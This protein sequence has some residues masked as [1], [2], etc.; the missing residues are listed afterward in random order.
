MNPA[1]RSRVV[2]AT[3][4]IIALFLAAWFM[5]SPVTA[6]LYLS[7]GLATAV[8]VLGL[9]IQWGYAGLFNAGILGF[10]ALG[11]YAVMWVSV[12][13][14]PEAI[15]AGGA[16]L[17]SVI[18]KL[19]VTAICIWVLHL[20]AKRLPIN[21][22]VWLLRTLQVSIALAG[23]IW[24]KTE[25]VIAVEAI[26]TADTLDQTMKGFIGGLGLPVLLGWAVGGV[27][28]GIAAWFI[29]KVT[30]G[31]RSDYLAIATLGIAEIIRTFL[32]NADW[33]TRGTLTV[34]PIDWPVPTP[35]E[36][37][38]MLESGLE[39]NLKWL[40]I[41]A[42]QTATAVGRGLFIAVSAIV[43]IILVLMMERALGSPWGRMMRAIRDNEDAAAAMGKN[44]VRRQLEVFVLGA[45][46]M[47]IGGAMLVS[48]N[49]LFDPSSYHPPR[50]TFLIWTMLIVGGSGN[51]LGAVFGALF[52]YMLWEMS[53]PI[54]QFL[55]FGGADM[56]T[57][58]IP[59][60]EPPVDLASRASQM[61]VIV[62]GVA[63]I[64]T[65]RYA[66]KG[67]IPER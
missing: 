33:L 10:I 46:L 63:L 22:P 53:E 45:I 48:L 11:G 16:G 61:R 19:A 51:N 60:F 38:G 47:G 1:N 62:I 50:Y 21:L 44:V 27:F 12:P 28:A 8:I 5:L 43:L 3:A 2:I 36:M 59:G 65:M 64:A 57:A 31:L 14:V 24:M 40:G 58:L 35:R 49:T 41:S 56:L 20:A 18:V 42:E 30:L 66:P 29:G 25:F 9:N 34:S 23:Y 13:P 55:F 15:A 17:L 6:L 54:A 32:K 67:V 26:E 4:L 37:N 52:I 7:T 39:I